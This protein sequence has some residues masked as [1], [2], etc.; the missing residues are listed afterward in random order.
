MAEVVDLRLKDEQIKTKPLNNG[1]KSSETE[2]KIIEV[3]GLK[4]K[5]E[6]IRVKTWEEDDDKWLEKKDVEVTDFL[7]DLKRMFS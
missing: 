3:A 1:D 4:L 2:K 6:L 5:D 7:A